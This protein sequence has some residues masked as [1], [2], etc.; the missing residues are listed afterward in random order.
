MSI[1]FEAQITV[2]DAGE[3]HT[4]E[5][6]YE[7]DENQD[8]HYLDIHHQGNLHQGRHAKQCQRL[9]HVRVRRHADPLDPEVV[10]LV[11]RVR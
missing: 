1:V 10:D 9:K 6:S 2:L 4:Q 7:V 11:S 8:V 5:V 3:I